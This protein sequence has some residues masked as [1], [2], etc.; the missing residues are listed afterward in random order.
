MGS[1][2]GKRVIAIEIATF[3]GTNFLYEIIIVVVVAIS[4]F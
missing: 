1:L 3:Y 2:I 4:T